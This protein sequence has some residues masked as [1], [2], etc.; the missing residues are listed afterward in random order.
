MSCLVLQCSATAAL[1]LGI[2]FH[3]G[4]AANPEQEAESSS[5]ALLPGA[6][7]HWDA[8]SREHFGLGRQKD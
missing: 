3:S 1:G 8:S 7:S 5:M 4:A 6:Q 2:L